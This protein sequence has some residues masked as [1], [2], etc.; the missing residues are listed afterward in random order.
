[1]TLS[2]A[3]MSAMLVTSLSVNINPFRFS[4]IFSP[5][6]IDIYFGVFSE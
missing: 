2:G 4:G 1:M 5:L 3:S 6:I